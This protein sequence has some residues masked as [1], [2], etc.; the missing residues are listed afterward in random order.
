MLVQ[1]I[2]IVVEKLFFSRDLGR[3]DGADNFRTLAVEWARW[4]WNNNLRKIKFISELLI[5]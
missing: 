3:L 4:Q 5:T 1:A 2:I